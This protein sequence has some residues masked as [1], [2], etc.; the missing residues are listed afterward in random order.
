MVAP[1]TAETSSLQTRERFQE[2]G[3]TQAALKTPNNPNLARSWP[4]PAQP[5]VGCVHIRGVS[6]A[7]NLQ[8]PITSYKPSTPTSQGITLKPASLIDGNKQ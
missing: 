3:L 7:D 4:A 2:A 5:P 6:D 1:T 8:A